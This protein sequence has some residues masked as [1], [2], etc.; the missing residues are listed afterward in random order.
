MSGALMQLVAYGAQ[1]VYLTGN[2]QITFFKVVYRRHTNFATEVIEHSFSGAADF[3]RKVSCP[4]IRNGDLA[5]RMWLKA[6]FPEVTPGGKFAWVRRLGHSLIKSTEIEIGG[7]RIDKQ[8]GDWLNIWYE[9]CRDCSHDRGYAEMIGDVPEMTKLCRETKPEFTTYVPLQFWFNRNT[10]LALPLIALQYHEVRVHFEFRKK[11]DL[12]IRNETATTVGGLKDAT[13]L[14]EYIYLDSEERRRF[15]QV[16]HE[17][18]IEQ[19]QF[20]GEE[21]VNAG[22]HKY[23]LNFN[24]PTK[25][26]IWM[27]KDYNYTYGKK[28]WA[29]SNTDDWTTALCKASKSIFKYHAVINDTETKDGYISQQLTAGEVGTI[30]ANNA[31]VCFSVS[32]GLTDGKYL[33]IADSD[34]TAGLP[35]AYTPFDKITRVSL[36]IDEDGDMHV[37][38]TKHKLNVR[39]I[40]M[41]LDDLTVAATEYVVV[42]QHHNY[43]INIDGSGN[44]CSDVLLQLN[45]HDRFDKRLGRWFNYVE[46]WAHHSN[47]PCDGLLSYSFALKPE[48]H[49][50]SGSA[51][52]SRIDTAQLHLTIKDPKKT[53]TYDLG[54]LSTDSNLFVYA[55]SYNVLRIMAG[56]GGLAYSS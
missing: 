44:S 11:E 35:S 36:V 53:S 17:Y 38:G 6:V 3:E 49:Q 45:G 12:Y 47:T 56:M 54:V 14:V 41:P 22:A 48:E 51:N 10:G 32:D 40:S 4:I 16:G 31:T 13:L 21:T 37:T 46:A 34:V 20:T 30:D 25:E 42:K 29:Y 28:F 5:T 7:A 18:L 33:H 50:P 2:P 26:L 43:G 39:D 15:A 24:H 8:Y 1:D 27:L 55:F 23:K 9:L 52:M 19:V